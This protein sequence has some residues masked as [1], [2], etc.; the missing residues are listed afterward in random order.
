LE[1]YDTKPANEQQHPQTFCSNHH[2]F[3]KRCC[4]LIKDCPNCQAKQIKTLTNETE[5]FQRVKEK[6]HQML[7]DIPII[8]ISQLERLSTIPVATGSYA[9]VFQCKWNVTHVALKQLRIKPNASQMDDIQLELALCI[10]MRHPNIVALFGQTKLEN[11]YMGLVMEWA[12]QGSLSDNM[13]DMSTEE[14]IKVSLCICKGLDY[15]HSNRIAHRDLKPENV[16]LFGNKSKAKISDF[17]TS[18][19]IQTIITSTAAVGTPKYSAPELMGEGLQVSLKIFTL[20]L[21]PYN[22]VS[23]FMPPIV[24]ISILIITYNKNCFQYGVSTDVYSLT[25]IIFELFSSINPFPGHIDEIFQAKMSDKKPVVP[26]TFPTELKELVIQGWSKEP[27]KRPPVQE[28]K[29]ALY[30]MLNL[31]GK[32]QFLTM[33][34]NNY[35]ELWDFPLKKLINKHDIVLS[36]VHYKSLQNR[37]NFLI[38]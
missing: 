17:G 21:C 22:F 12:D 34:N 27:K 29:L 4:S 19:V 25:I 5:I 1:P 11:N 23:Y 6:R 38:F 2:V 13:E 7:C 10:R 18:K 35:T 3:C 31:K 33:Q 28:F 32:E 24:F 36:F 9:E 15:M 8:P 14:K 37:R 26:S 16:L 30:K 20:F